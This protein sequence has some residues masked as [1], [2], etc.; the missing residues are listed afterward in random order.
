[1]S[2]HLIGHASTAAPGAVNANLVSAIKSIGSGWWQ[3]FEST[4]LVSTTKTTAQIRDEL[5]PHLRQTDRLVVV[6]CQDAAA[7]S[8]FSDMQSHWLSESLQAI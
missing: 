8:G 4:W 3:G 5:S 7:W 1:M 2:V 6:A